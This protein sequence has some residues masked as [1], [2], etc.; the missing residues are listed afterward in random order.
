MNNNNK[1]LYT[2]SEACELLSISTAT[3]RNWMKSGRLVSVA[4]KGK[5]PLFE[6]TSLF[7]LKSSLANGTVSGLKSRRNKNYITEKKSSYDNYISK[8]SPNQAAVK[9]LLAVFA[10]EERI[11]D[12]TTLLCLLRHCAEQLIRKAGYTDTLLFLSWL[13]SLVDSECFGSVIN[14]IDS[15][16]TVSYHYIPGEDTLGYLYLSL[17]GLKE[18]KTSGSYYTPP[19]LAKQLVE[20]HLPILKDEP[21]VFDPSCGTGMFLLQLPENLPLHNIFG[22]DID[23]VSVSLARINLSLKYQ[24]TTLKEIRTIQNNLFVSDFLSNQSGSYDII[25]GNPPW[26]A[27]LD[28][29]EKKN[30]QQHFSCA[31]GSSIEIYDL[32]IEQS[33][34]LLAPNGTLSFVLPEAVLTVKNH[35]PVRKLLLQHTFVRSVEYLGEVFEQVHCPSIILTVSN[36][37]FQPFFKNVLVILSD[38]SEFTTQVERIVSSDLFA[39]SLNDAEYLLLQKILSC[40]N[41]TT[42]VDRSVFALGIVTGNNTDTLSAAP[43]PGLEPIIKGNDISKFHIGTARH[44]IKFQSDKLQQTAPEELYRAPEKLFYRFINKQLTF[45]YDT[46]GLLSLNSCN[47]VIPQIPGL[48]VKYVMAVLNSSVAQFVFE[49]KF[50]SV[51]VLRSHLEQIP[52]PVTDTS[53]QEEIVALVDR[54][55]VH[56][57]DSPEYIKTFSFLD[58]KIATLYGLTAKEYK[59]IS[60]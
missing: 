56:K 40:P 47:I 25:L 9:Q 5:K 26:G 55:T 39:F 36:D 6:E 52:I 2:L 60:A 49:K 44:Y 27:K 45:A 43:A 42:L 30:Y 19:W 28:A 53:T 1:K 13:D 48:S 16:D 14:N 50:H 7:S 46:T 51:K 38:G 10:K 18:R 15:L 4:P 17:R 35:T 29:N 59:M 37:S 23:S 54:L 34:R 58:E 57:E 3:G 11:L 32:F 33:L 31:A 12:D 41:H 24:V 21:T 20:K 22:N 8:I